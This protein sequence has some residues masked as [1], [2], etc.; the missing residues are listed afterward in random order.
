M[1]WPL[2][3]AWV[4]TQNF[5]PVGSVNFGK[6]YLDAVVGGTVAGFIYASILLLRA[7]YIV[8]AHKLG[9]ISDWW[10]LLVV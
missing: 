3:D 10:N 1:T 4:C 9:Y 7:I 6:W 2:T 8:N 5:Y